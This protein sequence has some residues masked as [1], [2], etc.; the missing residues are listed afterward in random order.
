MTT[1]LRSGRRFVGGAAIACLLAAGLQLTGGAQAPLPTEAEARAFIAKVEETLTALAIRDSR[2]DWVQSTYIT[3]DTEVL[4]AEASEAMIGATTAFAKEAARFRDAKLPPELRRK[5]SLL[6]LLMPVPSPADRAELA[7]LTRI[8]TSLESDYGK[9]RYC[10]DGA[11][12]DGGGTSAG[13]EGSS[14]GGQETPGAGECLDITAIERL[15]AESRDPARLQDLWVGWRTISP[16]MRQRYTRFVELSNKGAR[17]LGFDDTGAM[18]RAKYDMP[19]DEFVAEVERLWAQV[20]PLYQSLHAYVR[21]RLSEHYGEALVPRNGLIPAHLLGNPWA[22]EW[23]NIYPLVAPEGAD[24]GFDLSERL[25]AT[26]VDARRMVRMGEGFFT[27][28][29]FGALP[30]TFWER[31]LFTKPADREVVCHASAWSIDMRDD[32][33]L[34]MCIQIRDDDFVTVHHEL[35]HTYYQLAYKDQPLLFKDSA[36]EAFHEAIGDTIALSVTPAYLKQAGLLEQVPPES[37][38]IGV[39]LDEALDKVAFLP[40][41]LLID[42]WRWRVFSGEI[43]PE[44]YNRAWWELRGRYQGVGAPV[45]RTEEHFDPGAKYHV[46]ANY[47]YT[48]YFIARLLQFQFHRALCQAAGQQ[49]PLH[50][51]SIYGSREAGERLRRTLEM[52]QSRPWPEAMEALTG[53]RQMDAGAMVEYFA[54]LKR[55]LDEQNKGERLGW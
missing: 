13:A 29:G 53:Q 9:G 25:R 40:F 5:I 36:N 14:G 32:V 8:A 31:S 55:W 33:R 16:P 34:K 11:A 7:E 45:T 1:F 38:D 47:S 12:T 2:A 30:A 41:G 43:R 3:P 48:R 19:P 20:Q 42:Q 54:P 46:P 21:R 24:R 6:R 22:Q 35:G 52:G 18:W 27:S 50:R 37:S 39:L 49:G 26:G 51:C 28:L 44:D 4:A 17:E 15:M 10:P 23:G